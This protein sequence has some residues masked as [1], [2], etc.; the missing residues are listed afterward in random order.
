MRKFF[1]TK[2]TEMTIGQT[3]IYMVLLMAVTLIGTILMLMIPQSA[4]EIIDWFSDKLDKV[5]SWFKRKKLND[6]DIKAK[7][8]VFDK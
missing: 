8:E 5:K 7:E 3:L 4:E 6:D 2:T 1:N